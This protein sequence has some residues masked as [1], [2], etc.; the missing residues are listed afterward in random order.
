MSGD[1]GGEKTEVCRTEP[2][3]DTRRS[4]SNCL[5]SPL[6]LAVADLGLTGNEMA[7][8]DAASAERPRY[9]YCFSLD[10]PINQD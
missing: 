4:S 10:P 6:V 2:A 9:P 3:C 8:L 1:I 7:L 5:C